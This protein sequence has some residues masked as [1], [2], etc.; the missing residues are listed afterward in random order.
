MNVQIPLLNFHLFPNGSSASPVN[1]TVPSSAVAV[2]PD[3]DQFARHSSSGQI[4]TR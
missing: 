3:A 4:I 2:T 1:D